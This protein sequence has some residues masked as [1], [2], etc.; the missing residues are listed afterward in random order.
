MT[1]ESTVDSNGRAR[2]C[3][4]KEVVIEARNNDAAHRVA[5]ILDAAAQVWDGSALLSR[6]GTPI[7]LK[8]VPHL[9]ITT[10]HLDETARTTRSNP[11]IPLECMLAVKASRRRN[12]VNA[13]AKLWLS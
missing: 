8:K 6:I 13:R 11:W 1:V 2:E 4:G 9:K 10:G 5:F 3:I 12:T 7:Q